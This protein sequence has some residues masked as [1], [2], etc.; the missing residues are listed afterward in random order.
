MGPS[1]MVLRCFETNWQ[2]PK[3][4]NEI[5]TVFKLINKLPNNYTSNMNC[6]ASRC[7][8]YWNCDF[9]VNCW[10][11]WKLSKFHWYFLAMFSKNLK[12]FYF[13]PVCPFPIEGGV[14]AAGFDSYWVGIGTCRHHDPW[15][16]HGL[17]VDQGPMHHLQIGVLYSIIW[18]AYPM[19][20]N[21]QCIR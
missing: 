6:I 11:V 1:K 16:Q 2:L 19:N 5:W 15:C 4:I 7:I 20:C 12:P 14:P 9:W 10:W 3:S 13:R 17:L 8:W 21:L 18:I